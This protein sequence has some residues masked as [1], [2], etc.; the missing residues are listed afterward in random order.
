MMLVFIGGKHAAK[1]RRDTKRD[2]DAGSEAGGGDLRR[3]TVAGELVACILIAAEPVERVRFARVS[4]DVGDSHAC[5]AVAAQI[6]SLQAISQYHQAIRIRKRQGPQQNPFNDGEDR[7]GCAD[8]KGQHQHRG[9]CE[10]W[11]FAQ[12]P[13]N[14]TKIEEEILHKDLADTCRYGLTS[15]SEAKQN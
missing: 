7:R 4:D 13:K 1:M 15:N 14:E 12:L 11:G 2:E 9:N 5:F 6:G 3:L 10:S 8:P